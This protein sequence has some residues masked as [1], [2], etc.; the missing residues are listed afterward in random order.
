MNTKGQT[1]TSL[2]V[3][4][5]LLKLLPVTN[6][7]WR[8]EGL[9]KTEYKTTTKKNTRRMIKE[10]S[11]RQLNLFLLHTL[12]LR[13]VR[14]LKFVYFSVHRSHT[15]AKRT[16]K[17]ATTTLCDPPSKNDS[18]LADVPRNSK[19]SSVATCYL[20]GLLQIILS[21]TKGQTKI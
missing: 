14:F 16:K 1:C 17:N 12:R 9:P 10:G 20:F 6:P 4:S 7:P 13:F 21:S 3:W 11:P 2:P 5:V 15:S 19:P 8:K 18:D